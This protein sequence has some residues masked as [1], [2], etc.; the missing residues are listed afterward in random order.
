MGSVEG[1]PS[2]RRRQD[3]RR[4]REK[5]AAAAKASPV[6]TVYAFISAKNP[7]ACRATTHTRSTDERSPGRE[8]RPGGHH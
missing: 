1:S 8:G 3:A 2:W 7:D 4:R 6:A 5:A